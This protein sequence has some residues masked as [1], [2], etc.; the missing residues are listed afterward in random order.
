MRK[1][2]LSVLSI[3]VLS[4][5]FI[6]AFTAIDQN[7]YAGSKKYNL[8]KEIYTEYLDDEDSIPTHLSNIKYDK[9]G[10]VKSYTIKDPEENFKVTYTTKYRDKK[11]TIA[12]VTAKAYIAG[13]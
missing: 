10:N 3:F 11:G 8:P 9:Y 6:F 7:V 12:S 5:T 4:L 2:K 13:T 1:K